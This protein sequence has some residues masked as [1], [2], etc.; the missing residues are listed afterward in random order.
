MHRSM[1][2]REQKEYKTVIT[3]V[4]NTVQHYTK[5]YNLNVSQKVLG[6]Q[7][8]LKTT[9]GEKR[10]VLKEDLTIF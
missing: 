9:S 6:V 10:W 4:S 1:V 2:I 8:N 5:Q 7:F 3:A